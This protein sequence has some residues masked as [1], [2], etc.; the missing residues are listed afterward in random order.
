[1][2]SPHYVVINLTD[3]GSNL[4][5]SNPAS[6]A[7][8]IH[9]GFT[10]IKEDIV[11]YDTVRRRYQDETI[12]EVNSQTHVDSI[13]C[14]V[15]TAC[16]CDLVG[17]AGLACHLINNWSDRHSTKY[18]S[19]LRQA[20]RLSARKNFLKRRLFGGWLFDSSEVNSYIA[21]H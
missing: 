2:I 8:L 11:S 4:I 14:F 17:H 6:V 7:A 3:D 16:D 21:S 19:A 20:K 15:N 12:A 9:S 13:F 1:V 10:K 5:A 18:D